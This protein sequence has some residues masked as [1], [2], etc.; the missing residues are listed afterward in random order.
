MAER[1]EKLGRLIS[2]E[3]GKILA[4][5]IFEASRAKETIE[6]SA[7]EAKRLD[8]EVLPLDGAS[9]WRGQPGLHTARSLRRGGRDH[10][11]QFSIQSGVPQGWARA[12]GRQCGDPQAGQR[13]AAVGF[14]V[15]GDLA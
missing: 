13:H 14:G 1:Q 4:E 7:E 11:I 5:G 9:E 6:L 3:E 12:G 8:G 10:A 15:G 2:S